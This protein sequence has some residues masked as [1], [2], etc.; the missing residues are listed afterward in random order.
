MIKWLTNDEATKWH[1][2]QSSILLAPLSPASLSNR[3]SVR[4]LPSEHTL[5]MESGAQSSAQQTYTALFK[6]LQQTANAKYFAGM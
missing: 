2:A 3:R 5:R 6:T 4:R 1:S